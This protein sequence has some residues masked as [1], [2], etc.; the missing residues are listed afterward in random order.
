MNPGRPLVFD[1]DGT[2]WDSTE[3]V[4]D[5]WNAAVS[6]AGLELG[7]FKP[8]DIASVMGLTHEQIRE[9]LFPGLDREHWNEFS[10]RAYARE[11]DFLRQRGGVLYPGVQAGLRLLAERHPLAIVSNCQKGYIEVF[12]EWTGLRPIFQDWECHGNTG[13]SKG[14]NIRR[15]CSRQ[16]WNDALYIGDTAGDEAAARESG[17]DF[18]FA[19]Y[20]FGQASAA[21]R[22]LHAFE[23]L[24]ELVPA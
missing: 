1:L 3:V 13:L 17:C 24:F 8:A 21:A 22:P 4:A 9:R 14:E 15:L 6:E 10:R 19:T 5:A 23:Q 16:N 18:L 2:L 12:L 11:E 20:G 7:S